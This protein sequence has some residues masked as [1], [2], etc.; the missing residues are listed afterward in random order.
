[1]L[2]VETEEQLPEI[3]FTLAAAPKK[4]EF[5]TARDYLDKYSRTSEAFIAVAPI[6]TPKLLTDL[7][8]VTF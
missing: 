1:M 8:A 5:N 2:N 7:A 6:P 3:W 4:Q